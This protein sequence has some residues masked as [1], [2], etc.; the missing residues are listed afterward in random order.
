MLDSATRALNMVISKA[1]SRDSFSLQANKFFVAG[2]H[3]PLGRSLCTMRGYF[4]SV[5]PGMGQM[6]LNLNACT[7]AF[8]QPLLVSQFLSDTI[9]IEKE[10]ERKNVLQGVRV[11]LTYSPKQSGDKPK[12]RAATVEASMQ[13]IEGCG[14][15][16]NKQKFLLRGRDGAQHEG[17]TVQNHFLRSKFKKCRNKRK[18]LTLAAYGMSLRYPGLPAVNCGT[19]QREI[20]YP[21]E[22]L[23]ILPYQ[24]Y[25]RKVPENLMRDMLTVACHHPADTRALIEHEGLRL[26]GL[27]RP[28][29][30]A[31]FV[32][33][34]AHRQFLLIY[35][36]LT[37]I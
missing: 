4:Y 30:F 8:F 37:M 6:L 27:E 9:T 23:Q 20:W 11:A 17:I 24:I 33:W 3:A 26:L 15:P 36:T 2:G 35:Q 7:S 13:S 29:G 34:I 25:R 16:C 10:S 14:L 21:P 5:R 12:S 22:V 31:P 32:S 1:L 19:R 18:P 28:G